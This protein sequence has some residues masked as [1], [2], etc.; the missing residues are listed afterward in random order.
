[1]RLASKVDSLRSRP[2]RRRPGHARRSALGATNAGSF[3]ARAAAAVAYAAACA[4][5]S[6]CGAPADAAADGASNGRSS[7]GIELGQAAQPIIGGALDE[8]TSAVVGLALDVG[9]R[10]AGHCSGTLIAPNLVLTARHCVAFTD[11]ADAEGAVECSTATFRNTFRAD[12][13][14]ASPNPV[15]PSDPRD[16]SYVRGREIRTLGDAGVC[17]FDIALIIL[18]QALPASIAPI[19]PRLALPPTDREQFST[20]G[21]GLTRRDDPASDGTR[22]RADGSVVRCSG[23]ACVSLS[24]GSIKSSEWASVDAPIC[25]GDSGGPALDDQGRVFGVAS[26]GDPDCEIAVYGDVANWAPFIVDTALDAASLGDYS[27]PAWTRELGGEP[28]ADA[29]TDGGGC[30]LS[31]TSNRSTRGTPWALGVVVCAGWMARR[32]QRIVRG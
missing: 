3:S 16:P 12:M 17:G 4:V 29:G 21:Y 10:I 11:T 9:A 31:P 1:M 30:S 22:Q 24:G 25:S 15:R 13:L 19:A 20:V 5:G 8:D 2:G 23:E 14:L 7:G 6:A 27:P 28:S 32:A 18:E 26:R